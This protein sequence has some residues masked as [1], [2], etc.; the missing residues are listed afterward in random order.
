MVGLVCDGQNS[1]CLEH[2]VQ[3]DVERLFGTAGD[4]YGQPSLQVVRLDQL[5]SGLVRPVRQ[6][7]EKLGRTSW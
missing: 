2:M 4:R 1:W 7:G 5:V 3:L 6:D